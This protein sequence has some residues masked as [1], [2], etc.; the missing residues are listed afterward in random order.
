MVDDENR[1]FQDRT[2]EAEIPYSAKP[3]HLWKKVALYQMIYS[4]TGLLIG[5]FCLISGMILFI[6]G[7]LGTSSITAKIVGSEININDTAPG[8]ILFAVGLLIVLIT[9]FTIKAK[10]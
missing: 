1:I 7:S 3:S 5:L 10:K 6:N 2:P 8:G 9:K 4:M